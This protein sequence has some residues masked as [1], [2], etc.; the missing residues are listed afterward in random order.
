MRTCG[1][2]TVCCTYLRINQPQLV[3]RGLTPC[4]HLDVK[5]EDGFCGQSVEGNCNIY[6]GRPPVCRD[7][8]CVWLAGY[9]EEEDRPDRCGVLIDTV[10]PIKNSI[11]AKPIRPNAGDSLEG[12]RAIHRMSR[13]TGKPALVARFPETQMVRVVG[14]GAE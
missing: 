13:D 5:S 7:Y 2:C 9:G 1:D 11:Q 6:Q 10:L 8:S 12:D 4:P 14:R 3:K